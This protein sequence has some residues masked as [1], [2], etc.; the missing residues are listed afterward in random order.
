MADD[1]ITEGDLLRPMIR[2][3]V[4]I[5][6]IQ[7]LQIAYNLT[8]AFWLGRLSTEAV[9]AVSIVVPLLL[10]LIAV[11]G[12]LATAGSILVAQYTG[13][14]QSADASRIAGQ[15]VTLILLTALLLTVLGSAF[16]D[17][18]LGLLPG[19]ADTA[20]EV[21]PL[22]GAYLRVLF[23][24][25]PFLFGF[26]VFAALLRGYGNTHT[27]MKVMV[28]SVV[29]N[30]VLDP[31]LIFGGSVIPALGIEGA[32]L[33]TIISRGVATVIGLYV[34]FFTAHG[35]NV[36]L[37]DLRPRG[38]DV[39]ALLRHGLPLAAERSS[40]QLAVVVQ[41][42]L[43]V[44]FTPEVVAAYGIGNRIISIVFLFGIG[45]SRATNTMVGQNLG[46]ENVRR[47]ERAVSVAVAAGVCVMIGL[48]A[49]VGYFARPLLEVFIATGTS[50]AAST[51][52]HGIDYLRI[53]ALAFAFV[54]I[55]DVLLGALRGAGN[56]RT[57]FAL[58]LIKL[59]GISLPVM[60][61]LVFV[62]D[63]GP[64]GIWLAVVV[65][66]VLSAVLIAAWY[67]RGTWKTA[68]IDGTGSVA[69]S[70]D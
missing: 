67:S 27:P 24:G 33:A 69:A 62:F 55:V 45:L 12:G 59:W 9:G 48:A 53:S 38:P 36:S 43:V 16:L 1:T 10:L 58:S 23:T 15:T 46:A 40:T 18:I 61:F 68:A 70:T 11:A 28:V 39:R 29:S 56:T 6:A 49:V 57:A 37:I 25:L 41:A 17:S 7:L 2:L 34:L 50:R 35:P 31:L 63:V 51:V 14:E 52:D 32:A 64:T 20:N 21:I 22:A 47:A 66:Y 65:E 42:A 8:D 30:F 4:P 3:A 26:S 44:T 54:A 13:A 5:I 60:Y 19:Q